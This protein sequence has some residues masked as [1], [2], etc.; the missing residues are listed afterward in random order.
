[1]RTQ[2]LLFVLVLVLASGGRRVA[3]AAGPSLLTSPRSAAAVSSRRQVP[4]VIAAASVRED[5]PTF[6]EVQLTEAEADAI[7]AAGAC[8]GGCGVDRHQRAGNPQSI[9]PWARC[10]YGPKYSGYY[11]GGGRKPLSVRH[12]GEG[13]YLDEGTWG[14]DYMPW[15]SRVR[16]QWTHGRLYQGG[17]GQYEQNHHVR[18]FGDF[19]GRRQH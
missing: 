15:Y 9:A 17:R 4:P 3:A 13:R 5:E 10:A 6:S 1:M 14:T 19:V 2:L 8:H 18:P 7:P 11:V 16:L 12:P